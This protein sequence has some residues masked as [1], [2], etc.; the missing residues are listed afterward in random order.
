MVIQKPASAPWFSKNQPAHPRSVKTSQHTMVTQ[1]PAS[2]P[3]FSKNQPAQPRSVKTSQH[4]MVAQKPAST[5]WFTKN[6][7]PHPAS[8][9]T[10]HHAQ[11]TTDR[12][13]AKF[14]FTLFSNPLGVNRTLRTRISTS[15]GPISIFSNFF[16]AFLARR[17]ARSA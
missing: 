16:F 4:M 6:Q 11:V 3:W 9:K 5:P 15:R 10:S 14:I 1:K 17:N 8:S 2:A 12:K 13:I 7:P